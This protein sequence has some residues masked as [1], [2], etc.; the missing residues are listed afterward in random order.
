MFEQLVHRVGVAVDHVEDAARQSGLAQEFAE[1]YRH[2]RVALGGLQD[3]GVTRGERV[4]GHPQRH[5]DGEVERRDRRDDADRLA[6]RVHVDAVGDLAGEV[7]L[8]VLG[9]SAGVLDVLESSGQFA[10]GVGEGL[11]VFLGDQGRQLVGVLDEELAQGEEHVGALGERRVAPRIGGGARDR[12]DV[13]DQLRVGDGN[14]R[15]HVAGGRVV[16]EEVTGSFDALIVD[17]IGNGPHGYLFLTR[18]SNGCT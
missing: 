10:F 5:H 9:E 16:D 12:D 18:Q 15:V 4:G 6:H 8:H 7:A 3:H 1:S 2:R 11:A 17:E 13:V 14:V